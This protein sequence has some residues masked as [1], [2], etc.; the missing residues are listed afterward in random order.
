MSTSAEVILGELIK[1]ID[2]LEKKFE[3]E[4]KESKDLNDMIKSMYEWQRKLVNTIKSYEEIL[5]E[6][7]IPIQQITYDKKSSTSTRT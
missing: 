4:A 6:H 3:I 1:K 5:S 7:H 2:S